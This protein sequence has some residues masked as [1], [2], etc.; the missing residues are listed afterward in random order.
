MFGSSGCGA[1]GTGRCVATGLRVWR[2]HRLT[3]VA[4]LARRI[5]VALA[6]ARWQRRRRGR[7]ALRT[8]GLL[9]QRCA[10]IAWGDQTRIVSRREVRVR[11]RVEA[12]LVASA[13]HVEWFA[14]AR[15]L[16]VVAVAVAARAARRR[17]T[18]RGTR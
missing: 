12:G 6:R 18:R 17:T 14:C 13:P 16:L 15:P 7:C 8:D 9:R 1:C 4:W 3:R 5:G 2:G 10:A 11:G